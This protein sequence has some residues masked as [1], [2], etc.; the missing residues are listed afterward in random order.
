MNGILRDPQKQVNALRNDI[1][2]Y[3]YGKPVIGLK[4]S[5]ASLPSSVY[6]H[7]SKISVFLWGVQMAFANLGSPLLRANP[8]NQKV[9]SAFM[10]TI[11]A[12]LKAKLTTA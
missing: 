10:E 8:K 4:T 11:R 3:A 7:V 2:R 6:E 9:L 5:K 1:V 12:D